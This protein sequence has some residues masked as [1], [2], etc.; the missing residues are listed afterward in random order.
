MLE[1]WAIF[2]DDPKAPNFVPV[3]I[4]DVMR[5][6]RPPD[7]VFK[8]AAK[9]GTLSGRELKGMWTTNPKSRHGRV[10][11]KAFGLVRIPR[12]PLTIWYG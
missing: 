10:A 2:V 12:T 9:T 7:D 11:I 3:R 5:Q 6:W 8:E 1:L 4:D